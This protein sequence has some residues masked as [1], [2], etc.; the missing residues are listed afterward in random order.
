MTEDERAQEHDL[1]TES[2]SEVEAGFLQGPRSETT[3]LALWALKIGAYPRGLHCIRAKREK[4]ESLTTIVTAGSMQLLLHPHTL[5]Y[6]T[7]TL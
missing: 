1:E 2:L 3:F 4:S 6:R 5:H 7:Q